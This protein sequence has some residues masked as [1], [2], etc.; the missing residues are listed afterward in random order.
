MPQ[1]QKQSEISKE[2]ESLLSFLENLC[3][4][5][6]SQELKPHIVSIYKDD[7]PHRYSIITSYIYEKIIPNQD[8]VSEY[9]GQIC[10]NL[11]GY[12]DEKFK[13][14]FKDLENKT[15]EQYKSK[16]EKLHDH[17]SLE[18]VRFNYLKDINNN[19]KDS[20]KK[21]QKV[22]DSAKQIQDDIN[23]QKNQYIVILGIFA[24][25]V[26]AFVGGM[27]FSGSVLSNMHQV[28]IYKLTFV[29]CFIALFFGNILF[30]LFNF[31]RNTNTAKIE[32]TKSWV[33]I[34]LNQRLWFN[35]FF[36]AVIIIDVLM[37]FD[38]L[39]IKTSFI[40]SK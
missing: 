2:S 3:D 23:Q 24:S 15:Q 1:K 20:A 38:K 39:G 19:I 4:Y 35:L 27:I 32:N 5:D 30:A 36:V 6:G 25:I 18:S 29:M 7:K 21:I 11:Q 13:D 17:I 37:Y 31:I 9:L 16:L 40:G 10:D 28:G 26:L 12:I 14:D 34:L 33:D 22:E 8:S